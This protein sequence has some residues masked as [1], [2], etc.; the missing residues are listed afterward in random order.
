MLKV[1]RRNYIQT[2]PCHS[3]ST[4]STELLNFYPNQKAKKEHYQWH[5]ILK[6]LHMEGSDC[7]ETIA[8]L[9]PEQFALKYNVH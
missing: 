1:E 4:C 8:S 7:G 3:Q 9:E 6:Q 2:V 5:K